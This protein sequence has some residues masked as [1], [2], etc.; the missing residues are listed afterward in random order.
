MHYR[1]NHQR[2]KP[3]FNYIFLKKFFHNF[4]PYFKKFIE[5]RIGI[6]HLF[7]QSLKR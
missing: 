7:Y 6:I 3:A 1:I 4:M 5:W 2:D